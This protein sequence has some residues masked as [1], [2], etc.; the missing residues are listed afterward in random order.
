MRSVDRASVHPIIATATPPRALVEGGTST[1]STALLVETI[2]KMI[3]AE[4]RYTSP[5]SVS[6]AKGPEMRLPT[7]VVGSGLGTRRCRSADG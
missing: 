1:D 6:D 5:P 3:A 4:D 7:R 2:G